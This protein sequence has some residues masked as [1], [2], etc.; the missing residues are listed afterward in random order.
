M[1]LLCAFCSKSPPNERRRSWV[2]AEERFPWLRFDAVRCSACGIPLPAP[3]STEAML[4]K[5]LQ[6]DRFGLGASGAPLL[7]W[8]SASGASAT[9]DEG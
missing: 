5:L 6:L 1:S 9:G 7:E 4:S 8:A 2:G 3:D